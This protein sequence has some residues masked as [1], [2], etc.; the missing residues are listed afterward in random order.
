ME[1]WKLD[2]QDV[3]VY[4]VGSNDAETIVIVV[5]DIFNLHEGRVKACCD[6]LADNGCKVYLPDW[7]LGEDMVRDANFMENFTKWLAKHPVD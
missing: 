6:F 5:H 2:N 7:H 1:T 3:P 4:T